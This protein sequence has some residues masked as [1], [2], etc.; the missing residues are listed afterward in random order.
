M[1]A[2][3]KAEKEI[4]DDCLQQLCEFIGEHSGIKQGNKVL[5]KWKARKDG[6][7]VFRLSEK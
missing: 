5:F 7:R 6:V 3:L 1:R 2:K 4:E